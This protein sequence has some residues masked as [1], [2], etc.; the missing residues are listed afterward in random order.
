MG[1]PKRHIHRSQSPTTGVTNILA[2]RPAGCSFTSSCR[3]QNHLDF[4][5]P[6]VPHADCLD[7]LQ[8]EGEHKRARFI[9]LEKAVGHAG[10]VTT[11]W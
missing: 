3:E 11:A 8:G 2:H 10:E 6:S 1:D 4:L 9:Y 7:S 5:D